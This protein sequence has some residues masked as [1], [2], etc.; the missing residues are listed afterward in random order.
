M[1]EEHI[2]LLRYAKSISRRTHAKPI[3]VLSGEETEDTKTFHG[4]FL[5]FFNC[6]SYTCNTCFL[7]YKL[8]ITLKD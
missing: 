3:G 2:H 6:L 7:I 8:N 1:G 5:A 4:R